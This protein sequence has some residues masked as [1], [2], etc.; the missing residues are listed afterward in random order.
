[1][2]F[3]SLLRFI[4]S[5]SMIKT[6][7]HHVLSRTLT[8]LTVILSDNEVP[9]VTQLDRK[10]YQ[11]ILARDLRYFSSHNMKHKMLGPQWFIGSGSCKT[12]L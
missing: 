7:K 5:T 12:P 3:M 8:I 11:F 6:M 1:M 10:Q 4:L 2:R 9:L